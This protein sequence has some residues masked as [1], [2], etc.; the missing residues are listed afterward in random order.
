MAAREPRIGGAPGRPVRDLVTPLQSPVPAIHQAQLDRV[1]L[2]MWALLRSTQA[3]SAAPSPSLSPNGMLGGSQAGA[4]LIYNLN[5]QLVGAM[6]RTSTEVGRRGGEVGLGLPRPPLPAAFRYRSTA[7]RRQAFGHDGGGRSAFA[8]F[9]E[10]GVY[11]RPIPLDFARRLSPGR[12]RRP[13]R[14]RPVRR[15]R[16]AVTRPCAQFSAGSASGAERSRASSALDVGPRITM[17]VRKQR[18][19]HFDYRQ[20]VPAMPAGLRTGA[21]LAGRFLAPP[22]STRLALPALCG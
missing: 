15:R 11:D 5:A 13:A 12:S 22:A 19:A 10:G 16:A 9:A 1:Q 20:R 17:Q 18:P 2:S 8:L 4:R 21:D 3:L 14:P 7:E 6:L